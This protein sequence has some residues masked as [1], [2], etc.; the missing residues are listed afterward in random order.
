MIM[1][2]HENS[3]MHLILYICCFSLVIRPTGLLLSAL[4]L[5]YSLKNDDVIILFIE[6]MILYLGLEPIS[7]L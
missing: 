6:L 4:I 7:E 3:L 2:G 1:K 5:P